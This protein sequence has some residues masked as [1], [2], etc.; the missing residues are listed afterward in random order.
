MTLP[1]FCLAY[2]ESRV[3]W[4]GLKPPLPPRNARFSFARVLAFTLGQTLAGALVGWVI[5]TLLGLAFDHTGPLALFHGPFGWLIWLL[6]A[7]SAC[8]GIIGYGF[9]ALCWNHRAAKL[10]N[11]PS[12][13]TKLK[14]ARYPVFRW[15]LGLVYF[16]TLAVL[17]PA[18][19]LLTIENARGEILWRQERNKL[20][21]QGERLDFRDILGPTVPTEQNAG[22]APIFASFFDYEADKGEVNPQTG[23]RST[24]WHDTN[25][26]K[27]FDERMGFP[28]KFNPEPSESPSNTPAVNLAAW[29]EAYRK[30]A[31]ATNNV[32][33]WAR[34][35]KLPAATND[36]AKVVLA[37]L[38]VVEKELSE[39]CEATA[40]PRS[41]FPIHWEEGVEALLPHAGRL[42]GVQLPLERRCAA[43]LAIG[44]TN[45]A[46]EDAQ[47]ALRVSELL[48]EEPL[49]ISQLIRIVQNAIAV[50]VVW[51]GLAQHAWTDAQLAAFQNE[52]ARRDLLPG[53]VLAFEG[54]RA[55]G[56]A[57]VDN[58]I[59]G[60]SSMSDF[61]DAT[62]SGGSARLPT[63]AFSRGMFR[64][65]EIALA[66][67]HTLQI[68]TIRAAIS[69]APQTGLAAVAKAAADNAVAEEK[70]GLRSR[71]PY[72]VLAAMLAPATGGAVR[73]AAR[74][75]T[76]LR[77][78]MVACALERYH[79]KQNVFPEKLDELV[80]AFLPTVPL[81]PMNN[82][83]FHYQRTD[84]GWFQLYSVGL[85][86]QDDGGVF[87]V[88]K[89]K[90]EEDLDWP[91]PVPSR[92]TKKTIF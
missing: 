23:R 82:Q 42:K 36:S 85:N 22:T 33:S 45:A 46:F 71:S 43:H 51:Q 44:E 87:I 84:D 21:A 77:M 25:A 90:K 92:Q 7:F 58:W 69:N 73:R 59:S 76:T 13:D 54:E 50:R 89:G 34:E 4:L 39:I 49:L 28:E 66:R 10:L 19:L 26:L 81:D 64:Q 12:L 15:M 65:N 75:E 24:L 3:V 67:Y 14:P 40:R 61:T 78:A 32:P 86:G 52:F 68:N 56:I 35:L 5:A 6:A 55:C 8:Q 18:L 47:C 63:A 16:L 29:A 70:A 88:K 31:A 37:G 2:I 41:Q 27:R 30:I 79:L 17:M 91:W 20:I 62:E 74:A 80:P 38:A 1:K 83:P 72:R 11:D 60:R 48:R 57:G 9:T 53:M